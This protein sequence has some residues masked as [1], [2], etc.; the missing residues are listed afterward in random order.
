M[1]GHWLLIHLLHRFDLPEAGAIIATIDQNITPE[2]IKGEVEFLLGVGNETFERPY[3]WS[4]L[5]KL[6]G[7]LHSVNSAHADRWKMALHPLEEA[8]V[9]RFVHWL[10]KLEWP[11]RTGVHS[12]TAF[13]LLFPLEYARTTRNA[14]FENLIIQTARRLYGNDRGWN[15]DF[16]PSGED[17]L[18]PSLMEATLMS[19]ILSDSEFV[20]WFEGF[21]PALTPDTQLLYPI[22]AIDRGDPKGGHLDG[23]N[24]SRAWCLASLCQKLPP[25]HRYQDLFSQ[26]AKSHANYG[27]RHIETGNYMGEHW[28]AS[29]ALLYLNAIN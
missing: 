25:S 23:L 14:L 17:F 3:G 29:F 16:E 9:N 21:L 4:W 22:Q 10:P 2:T 28:L 13:G 24:L 19:E 8:V 1:H 7:E 27:L 11:V 26:A 12:N 20:D 5:L 18:S 6:A 15:S